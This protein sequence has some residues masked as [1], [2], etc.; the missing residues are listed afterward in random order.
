MGFPITNKV[1]HLLPELGFDPHSILIR[2]HDSKTLLITLLSKIR[3][4]IR[5]QILN[6]NLRSNL[7]NLNEL[8][9]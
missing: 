3:R 7:A 1:G 6:S 9:S 2:H 5:S 8:R 4:Q